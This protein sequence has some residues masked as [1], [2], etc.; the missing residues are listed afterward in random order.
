M[1]PLLT[2]KRLYSGELK[3]ESH[4]PYDKWP[5]IWKD[6]KKIGYKTA[7]I[8][9][10]P[11][12]TLFNYEAKG[13]LNPP[14][15]WYPHPFWIHL[16]RAIPSLLIDIMPFELSNCYN[17]KIPKIDIFLNQ[18]K[19]FMDRCDTSSQP[20]F[21]FAFYIEVTHNDFNKAQLL[22]SHISEFID[23]SQ[24]NFNNTLFILMVR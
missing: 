5:F 20:C 9:D 1:I 13:F 4:G 23:G 24:R 15:D 10:F 22:D 11:T 12:F 17:N 14:T 18:L 3:N 19:L 7:L 21:A 2:G 6:F 8:E 16:Y